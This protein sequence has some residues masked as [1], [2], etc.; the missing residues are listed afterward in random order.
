V[1]NVIA[2]RAELAFYVDADGELVFLEMIERT[3][4][5]LVAGADDLFRARLEAFAAG[6]GEQEPVSSV[7]ST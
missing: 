3:Y 1:A 2:D 6:R 7:S 5:H 4:G